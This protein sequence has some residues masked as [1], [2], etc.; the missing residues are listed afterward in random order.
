MQ[1]YLSTNQYKNTNTSDLWR[2]LEEASSVPVESIMNTWV[3][4][5]GFPLV[6]VRA[7]KAILG[8]PL[9]RGN[10]TTSNSWNKGNSF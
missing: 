7:I 2:A 5:M 9:L 4:Q 3:K 10:F 1:L 8:L 6:S